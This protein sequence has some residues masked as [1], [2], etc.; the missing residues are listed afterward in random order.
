[1]NKQN[2]TIYVDKKDLPIFIGF[3][4][5][6]DKRTYRINDCACI[7]KQIATVILL[8]K[9]TLKNDI[10]CAI[11]SKDGLVYSYKNGVL[12][13][14]FIF[15]FERL[16]GLNNELDILLKKALKKSEETK[17]Y[18]DLLKKNDRLN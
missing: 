14:S 3:L 7:T 18:S 8:I 9:E 6:V 17:L 15:D 16:H 13:N 4:K 11:F 12:R 10:N 5:G 2:F 1:M